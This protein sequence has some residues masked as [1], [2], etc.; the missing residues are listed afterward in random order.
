M[1]IEADAAGE[2]WAS[3][4]MFDSELAATGEAKKGGTVAYVEVA[5]VVVEIGVV[6]CA[7][8]E[9]LFSGLDA[10]GVRGVTSMSAGMFASERK[11][12]GEGG[13]A[14]TATGVFDFEPTVAGEADG[15]MT[16]DGEVVAGAAES[17]GVAG[18]TWAS[19][20]M[21]DSELNAVGGMAWAFAA[22]FDSE[23]AAAAEA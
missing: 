14:W 19:A 20:E 15:G 16:A 23:L 6:A 9:T 10:A 3:P 13:V 2:A 18:V 12:A 7:S 21:F 5:A 8:A 17:G 1:I 22:I 4:K 11:T